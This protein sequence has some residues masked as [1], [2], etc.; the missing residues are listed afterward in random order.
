MA[1]C[2]CANVPSRMAASAS[3]GVLVM[4]VAAVK[5]GLFCPHVVHN[6]HNGALG[7]FIHMGLF[8]PIPS[9]P[10]IKCEQFDRK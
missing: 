4:W 3:R 5:C 1:A 2:W 10:K 7:G 8:L 6:R 9:V